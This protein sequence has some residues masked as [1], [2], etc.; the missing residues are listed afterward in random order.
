MVHVRVRKH[1]THERK[2]ASE[3]SIGASIGSEH[4]GRRIGDV[5]RMRA[6][7]AC[8]GGA[9]RGRTLGAS[10]KAAVEMMSHSC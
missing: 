3:A 6:S 1:T 7:E 8:I 2:R 4:R 9:Y 10:S 5:H